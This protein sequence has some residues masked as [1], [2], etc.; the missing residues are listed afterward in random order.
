MKKEIARG[1]L[2]LG[3]GANRVRNGQIVN[4]R[5]EIQSSRFIFHPN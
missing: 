3:F 2:W 4:I 5:V 1:W